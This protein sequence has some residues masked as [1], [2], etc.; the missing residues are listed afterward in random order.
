VLGPEPDL[1]PAPMPFEME[2]PGLNYEILLKA[3]R[4]L[5]EKRKPDTM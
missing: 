2:M 1:E 4:R 3:W 5:D